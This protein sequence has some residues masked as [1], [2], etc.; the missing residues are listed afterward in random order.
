[1]KTEQVNP[2]EQSNQILNAQNHNLNKVKQVVSD[3][4]SSDTHRSRVKIGIALA[5]VLM[6][7]QTGFGQ[8]IVHD[9]KHM[10]QNGI[11]FAKNLTELKRH[12]TYRELMDGAWK[13][14]LKLVK[15]ANTT[16]AALGV[17]TKQLGWAT[18]NYRGEKAVRVASLSIDE[19][20]KIIKGDVKAGENLAQSIQEIYGEIP[21]TRRG[22]QVRMAY[23]T[24][25]GVVVNAGDTNKAVKEMLEN[26]EKIQ[27]KLE[28]G[29]LV[30]GDRE[31]LKG[32]QENLQLRAQILN[33]QQISYSNQLQA[34]TV[35]MKA[36][37]EAREEQERLRAR[38]GMLGAIGSIAFS[39]AGKE[40]EGQE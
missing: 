3:S 36:A 40:I 2:D 15:V 11:E 12:Q 21:V 9:P 29:N 34:Q 16:L 6:F 26:S 24:V 31:R 1:M 27:K 28:D 8:L 35:A 10:I 19:V 23:E 14:P 30:N 18:D 39:P 38:S 20:Q 33:L 22:A 13:N 32:Q 17:D 7:S 5:L 25:S 37:Q 4:S